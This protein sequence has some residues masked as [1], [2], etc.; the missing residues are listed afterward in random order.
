LAKGIYLGEAIRG[1]NTENYGVYLRACNYGIYLRSR[2]AIL[3]PRF[4]DISELCR[5]HLIHTRFGLVRKV[6][7]KKKEKSLGL[8][9]RDAISLTRRSGKVELAAVIVVPDRDQQNLISKVHSPTAPA[10]GSLRLPFSSRMPILGNDVLRSWMERV[11]NLGVRNLWI[12][13]AAHDEGESRSRL[14]DMARQ[15][16]ERLLMI[17]LKS[18]AEM[19]L[20]DLFHFHCEKCN[21]VTEARDSR[22]KLG[23]SLMDCAALCTAEEKYGDSANACTPVPYPFRGYAKRILAA[24]ERQEL[25]GD[26]LTGAC[27]MRPFGTEIREQVWIGEGANLADSVRVIGPTYIGAHTVV[28]AGATIGPFAS[29]ERDC[30]IDCG[31]TV[32]RATVLPDTYLAPGLLIRNALVDGQYLED[33]SWGAVADLQPAGLGGRIKR[34]G[35]RPQTSNDTICSL[36]SQV[37]SMHSQGFAPSFAVPQQWRQVQL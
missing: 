8:L 21:P 17:K 37:D 20:T 16:I 23:V 25:V 12:A 10:F 32:E 2:T 4:L 35:F 6:R 34:R 13:P 30:V 22:G 1:C 7:R 28:R 24:Q 9:S 5:S 19:D 26:A 15:G 3:H 33:L 14:A 36:L 11:R 31:T 29:I 18:Y 27:A